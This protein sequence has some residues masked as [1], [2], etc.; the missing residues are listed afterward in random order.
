[1]DMDSGE[2]EFRPLDRLWESSSQNWRLVFFP[3]GPSRMI[4]GTRH[5][6]DIRSGTFQGFAA[7]LRPLEYSEYLTISLDIQSYSIS[8]ELPRFRLSFFAHGGELELKNMQGMVIDDN[9]CTGTMIGLS[10]QLVLCHKDSTFA[11][12]P[13]SRCV[14]IPRGSVHFS[15]SADRNHVRLHIDTRTNFTRRVTWDRYE[16]DSDLGLLVGNVNLTSRLYRIYLHAL[17]SHPLPDP[18]TGQTGTDHALQELQAAGSFSFQKLTEDDVELLRL[19]G[20]ITPRREYYPK[21]LS[22]MQTINWSPQLPA[23]S[24]HHMFGTAV[25]KILEYAQSLTTFAGLKGNNVD[26]DYKCESASVLMAR[27]TRRN[28]VYY[29]GGI[30]ASAGFD[31]RYNSRDLPYIADRDSHGIEALNTSQLVYAWPTGLTRHLEPSE[32]IKTFKGWGNMRGPMEGTSLMYTR[33]WLHVDLP[34]KWLSIYDI[35]RQTGQHALKYKLVFSF[36]ALSF[37]SPSLRKFIPILLAFATIRGPL[38]IA[39]PLHSS[40]DLTVGFEALRTQVRSMIISRTHLLNDSPAR[41]LL[42]DPNESRDTFRSRQTEHYDEHISSR[43]NDAADRL[44]MECNSSSPQ[45]PFDQAD[46]PNW[47]KVEKIMSDVTEYFASCSRNRDLR[48]FAS[49]VTTI[50]EGNYKISP[51]R[52]EQIPGF[53]FVPQFEVTLSQ[54]DSSFTLENLLFYRADSAPTRSSCEIETG[55]HVKHRPLDQPID[56]SILENLISQ[57]Q[58]KSRSKLTQLYSE[59]LESSRRE[60]HRQQTPA[61]LKRIPPVSDC[62]A[63]RDHC[64]GRLHDFFSSIRS[65]LSPSTTTERILADAG[66]WPRLHHRSVLHPLASTANIYLKPEWADILAALAEVFIEYQHSQRLLGYALQSDAENFY[67][68]LDSASFSRRDAVRNSDWLLIQVRNAFSYIEFRFLTKPLSD[69]RQFHHPHDPVRRGARDDGSLLERQHDSA[70]QHG[71]GEVSRYRTPCSRRPGR[72]AQARSSGC[73]EASCWSN[74]PS[75]RRAYLRPF[76]SSNFLSS[77]LP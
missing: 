34:A 44:M 40:Y 24:Q 75:A 45:S 51:Q 29:E 16:V 69:P 5:L 15:F 28:A 49:Q 23:L 54:P 62:L 31:R 67:K 48:S 64:K 3:N 58:R 46:D 8:I 18:L 35:C 7:R 10:S 38:F 37:S 47:F 2:V 19:I 77:I 52:G 9:Q 66:L 70:A 32:L 68:E 33:E 74:V 4:Q 61:S 13:R 43:A 30:E 22:V 65:S 41:H 72:L 39:P 12:L 6:L 25:R 20:N 63:Y 1:M 53:R 42:R 11:S 73:F 60:L 59:R 26:L 17:C 76:Q 57:F 56:T 36:A 55:A 14:L 71:R 50:L 21:H 27:A